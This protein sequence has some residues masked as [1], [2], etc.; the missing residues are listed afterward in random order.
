[1]I[2]PLVFIYPEFG[3]F[4]YVEK[5]E[6]DETLMGA[7]LE[8]FEAGLPWD[9]KGFYTDVNKLV[10]AIKLNSSTSTMKKPENW[11]KKDD[12]VFI[13]QDT[14]LL[15][16]IQTNGYVVPSIP[17]IYVLSGASPFFKLFREKHSV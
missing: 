5:T 8:I 7:F 6:G 13:G 10:F 16:T 9:D 4:D 1:M 11:N 3:Q 15:K 17:E 12:F 2:F 14:T